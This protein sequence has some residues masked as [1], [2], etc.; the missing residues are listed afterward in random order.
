MHSEQSSLLASQV[1]TVPLSL[2]KNHDLT[3]EKIFSSLGINHFLTGDRQFPPP[4]PSLRE[5]QG[6]AELCCQESGSCWNPQILEIR[7]LCF[8]RAVGERSVLVCGARTGVTEGTG[9]TGGVTEVTGGMLCSS[10]V[11]AGTGTGTQPR[12]LSPALLTSSSSPQ[13]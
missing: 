12:C 13:R 2:G 4:N 5:V 11:P 6:L 10:A 3:G 1:C 8:L 7:I 9:V